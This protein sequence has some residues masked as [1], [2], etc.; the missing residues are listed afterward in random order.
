LLAFHPSL[1]VNLLFIPYCSH[2]Q[3]RAW[4]VPPSPLQPRSPSGAT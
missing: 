2:P 1:P 4:F 3:P